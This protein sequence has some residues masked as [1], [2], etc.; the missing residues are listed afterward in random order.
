MRGPETRSRTNTQSF[1]SFET[2]PL[3]N[4]HRPRGH[5]RSAIDD[6]TLALEQFLVQHLI[7]VRVSVGVSLIRGSVR[8]RLVQIADPFT[9]PACALCEHYRDSFSSTRNPIHTFGLSFPGAGREAVPTDCISPSF[10]G[11]S[12]G[13]ASTARSAFFIAARMDFLSSFSGIPSDFR[14]E[15]VNFTSAEGV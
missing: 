7:E 14:E 9:F 13:P 11:M 1:L 3:S 10:G 2:H 12:V 15:S 6:S 5:N 4:D 8:Q